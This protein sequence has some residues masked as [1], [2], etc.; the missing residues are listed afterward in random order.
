MTLG[1][2]TAVYG[3]ED[4]TITIPR[5]TLHEFGRADKHPDCVSKDV[6]LRIREW[7]SPPDG[8]KEAFFRNIIGV[9][10][11][12]DPSAG[13]IGNIKLLFSMFV[14]MEEHD[15]Y[16]V[17]IKGP[18]ILGSRAQSAIRRGATY[19]IRGGLSLVGRLCGFKGTYEEYTP[20]TLLSEL[21]VHRKSV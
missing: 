8:Q 14:V 5:Y 21:E 19:T 3:P 13:I 20:K 18:A 16:P 4:G 9:L 6:D 10:N 11:D 2:K 1:D 12:R 17:F 15:T 7:T